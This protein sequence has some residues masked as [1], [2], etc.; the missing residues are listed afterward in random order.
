[1]SVVVAVIAPTRKST[2]CKSN[3]TS[4]RNTHIAQITTPSSTIGRKTSNK[5][6]STVTVIHSNWH[7]CVCVLVRVSCLYEYIYACVMPSDCYCCCGFFLFIPSFFCYICSVSTFSI[8]NGVTTFLDTIQYAFTAHASSFQT[9][10]TKTQ[11]KKRKLKHIE[12]IWMRGS[13]NGTFSSA[14]HTFRCGTVAS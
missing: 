1:M 4:T 3:H 6:N 2:Y 11:T 13:I 12:S 5:F 9:K 7:M 8:S 14:L 10:W